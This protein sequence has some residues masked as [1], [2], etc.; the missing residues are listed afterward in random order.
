MLDADAVSDVLNVTDAKVLKR[1]LF[2]L[3]PHPPP[4]PDGPFPYP[5]L[6]GEAPGRAFHN[7]NPS[8]RSERPSLQDFYPNSAALQKLMILALARHHK[9]VGPM[10]MGV[11]TGCVTTTTSA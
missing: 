9:S 5:A 10:S 11:L 7:P 2:S 6:R 4:A 3:G 8:V 1:E